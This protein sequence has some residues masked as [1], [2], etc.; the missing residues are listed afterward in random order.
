VAQFGGSPSFAQKLLIRRAARAMLR[1]ELLD[2]KMAAGNWTDHDSR[3]FGGLN[4][5]VSSASAEPISPLGQTPNTSLPGYA[6]RRPTRSRG[7]RC[8]RPERGDPA[9]ELR[10]C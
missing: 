8:F 4:N 7:A 1:L 10:L 3:T 2:E 9:A 5:A 6:W